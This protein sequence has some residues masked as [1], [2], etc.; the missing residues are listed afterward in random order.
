MEGPNFIECD[1]ELVEIFS[2]ARWETFYCSFQGFNYEVAR[3][4]FEGFDGR[5]TIVA[6]ISFLVMEET[7]VEETGL[8]IEREHWFKN[9]M[10]IGVDIAF[11][12]K[13]EHMN[14]DYS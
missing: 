6:N 4:F 8:P 1:L 11:F 5:I 9:Q 12:L 3:E 14:E 13:E 7:I 2:R 10:L